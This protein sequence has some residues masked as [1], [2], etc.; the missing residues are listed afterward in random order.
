MIKTSKINDNQLND[1]INKLRSWERNKEELSKESIND[2]IRIKK[3]Y[4]F[5]G[6]IYL[7]DFG[8]NIGA[9]INKKR[10]ALVVSNNNYN[11]FSTNVVVLPITKKLIFKGKDSRLPK[12]P[13]HYFLYKLDYNFLDFDSCVECEQIRTMSK[14]RIRKHL[15]N[16][17]N[18]DKEKILLKLNKLFS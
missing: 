2:I 7:V 1:K 5:N 14:A 8:E 12:Y 9:E 15:G 13:S 18:D 11:A 6:S 4:A 3:K 10:P 17:K 16:L